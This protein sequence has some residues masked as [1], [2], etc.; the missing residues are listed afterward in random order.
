MKKFQV[1]FIVVLLFPFSNS[2]AQTVNLNEPFIQQH[3][4][5]AQLRGDFD[6]DFSFTLKPIH[7]GKNGVKIDPKVLYGLEYGSTVKTFLGKHGKVKILPVDFL[8]EYNSHHPYNRNNGS[9][10]PNRGYQQ[11]ISFGIYA[12][13]GPLSIQLKPEQVYAEN[14]NFEGFAD[15]HYDVIWARRY[16]TWNHIDLPERFGEKSYKKSLLGQSSIRLNWKGLSLGVSTE[17]LWWGP[18]IR[19]SIMMSNQAQGFKHITF[20][21]TK[22]LKTPIGN[23][24]WQLVTGRLENSGFNPPQT[25][26]TSAGTRLFTP[27][28]NQL[29]DTNDWRFIQA[30]TV[31][32]SPKW[33]KG[34]SLGMI[35]WVQMY[36]A[37]IEG[38]YWWMGGKP[39][40]GYFP[41][42]SN[43]L[44]S[45]DMNADLEQ[46]TDQAAG[47]F[48][49][50]L[51]ADAQMEIYAEFHYN[52]AK[53]NLRDLMLDSDHARAATI[54]LQKV[55]KTAKSDAYYLFSWEWTQLEQ[56]GG[57][58][59]RNA[60]SWYMHSAV[61][62]GYTNNG[63]VLGAGIGPGSNSHYFSVTKVDNTSK[64]GLA[65]EI[66]D[67]DND[68]YYAAFDDSN[69]YRRYWKDFNV[70]VSYEKKYK[71]FW[72]SLN[73]MYSRS[74]NY[75]W[76]LEDFATPYYH[77]GRD[78]NNFHVNFKLTYHLN[79]K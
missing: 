43:F 10:I 32:Y 64:Y 58:L 38:K 39:H 17:N 61:Y 63:E 36:S 20:N 33:I 12:E 2:Q 4:R 55:F 31:T 40:Y 26:R 6:P 7:T 1:L 9:M 8:M 79:L 42:F 19:N 60:G 71:N 35:R 15:S 28:I 41:V 53:Q 68:F 62:D 76:E 18:S 44:R 73:M 52:D 24:E 75:Q 74:L 23:F 59:L 48:M 56:T 14:R 57:K 27:R 21:T 13:L 22:P 29:G 47:L 49:R 77:A 37:M 46:Q 54:G 11:L 50:W 30:Y 5:S 67:Q 45:N 3:L 51:W 70:H 72:G 78:V 65:L 25:D 66:I 34:L 69:D 16:N